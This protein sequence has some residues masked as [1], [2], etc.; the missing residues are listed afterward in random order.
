MNIDR[1]SYN[2]SRSG[3][4]L[5]LGKSVK[6]VRKTWEDIKID[7]DSF[8]QSYQ[9]L[10]NPTPPEPVAVAQ[11]SMGSVL[12]EAWQKV[13]PKKEEK[14]GNDIIATSWDEMGH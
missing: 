5:G 9:R 11:K 3:A 10:K 4:F 7:T 1:N 8:K 13:F 14:A 2:H 12:K 6:P